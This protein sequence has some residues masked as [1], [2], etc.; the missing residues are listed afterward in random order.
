MNQNRSTIRQSNHPVAPYTASQPDERWLYLLMLLV[1]EAIFGWLLYSTPALRT[2]PKL[3]V[4]TTLFGLH[5]ALYLLAPRLPRWRGWQIHYAIVQATLIFAMLLVTSATPQPMILLLYASLA[6]QMVALFQGA[7]RPAISA[8]ALFLCIVVVDYVAFW[9]WSALIGFLLVTLPLTA[10]LMALVYLYLRQTHARQEAQ[11]LLTA[12]EAAHQQLAAYAERVEDLT[13]AAER[14]RLA[15]ELHD[16]LAQGL[17]GLL[18]QLEAVESHL[19]RGNTVRAQ[20]IIRQAMTRARRT[21]ADARRA[22][23]DL[24]NGDFLLDV[25]D[26]VGAEVERFCATTGLAC[27][28][29]LQAPARLPLALHETIVRTVGEGLANVARHAQA[30]QVWVT[31]RQEAQGIVLVVRDDGIGFDPAATRGNGHYGLI[32]LAERAHHAGG[33][34]DVAGAPGMGT[35]LTLRL[36]LPTPAVTNEQSVTKEQAY[37]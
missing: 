15:R 19:E 21:L 10:F 14:Q 37:A 25:N 31:L 30:R 36:P 12:L 7:L 22:I 8:A 6:A 11:Q 1:P 20:G 33:T 18:L 35:T 27:H 28:H 34:L 16:T 23:D 29:E 4:I 17:A 3:L 32:G 5:G 9:G 26:N 13:L 24:R 2:L